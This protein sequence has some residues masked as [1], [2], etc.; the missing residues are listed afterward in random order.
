MTNPPPGSYQF[1]VLPAPPALRRGG[2]RFGSYMTR[3]R[4]YTA[5]PPLPLSP[6][7]PGLRG[8]G[9]RA[10]LGSR[11]F[12]AWEPAPPRRKAGGADNV[13]YPKQVPRNAGTKNEAVGLLR[14]GMSI[15]HHEIFT[16]GQLGIPG[17][18]DF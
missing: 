18:T 7:A 13:F 8:R 12:V 11:R 14:V 17:P 9:G 16:T 3:Q 2:A 1:R 15:C 4:N 10:S 6:G 5:L